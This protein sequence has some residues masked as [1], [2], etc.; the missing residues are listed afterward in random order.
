MAWQNT[1]GGGRIRTRGDQCPGPA[2]GETIGAEMATPSI[3]YT[4]LSPF[5]TLMLV[6]ILAGAVIVAGILPIILKLAGISIGVLVL[7]EILAGV[8]T[9]AKT[10]IWGKSGSQTGC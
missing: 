7:F 1:P 5:E 2:M 4:I 9:L 10:L 6:V 8:L 3:H